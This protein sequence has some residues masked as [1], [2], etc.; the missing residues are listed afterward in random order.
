M[1]GPMPFISH[2]SGS[3]VE[4]A[5][6][7]DRSKARIKEFTGGSGRPVSCRSICAVPDLREPTGSEA[8]A[9]CRTI[10]CRSV[11][12]MV[13]WV[14]ELLISCISVLTSA[15][16]A[17]HRSRPGCCGRAQV[18]GNPGKP[19]GARGRDWATHP[20]CETDAIRNEI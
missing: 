4:F 13:W 3:T 12:R 17:D 18:G 5:G 6:A 2:M 7:L 16:A 14:P 15:P 8:C 9:R 1:L 19:P 20:E 11:V 10:D